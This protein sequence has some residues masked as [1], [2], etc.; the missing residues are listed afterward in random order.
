MASIGNPVKIIEAPAPL[1]VPTVPDPDPQPVEK[2]VE[3]TP[4]KEPVPA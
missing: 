3:K 1:E 4:A 2:P